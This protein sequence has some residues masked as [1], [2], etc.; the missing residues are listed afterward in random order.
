M[1]RLKDSYEAG[2]LNEILAAADGPTSDDV[3]IAADGRRLDSAEAVISFF[4]EL[5]ANRSEPV[6]ND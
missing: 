4:E 1:A 6:P 5:R 2:E 3:S